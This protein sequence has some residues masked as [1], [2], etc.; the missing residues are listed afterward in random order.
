MS[1]FSGKLISVPLL[2]PR[3]KSTHRPVRH[4]LQEVRVG[5][6]VEGLSDLIDDPDGWVW[7]LVCLL[8][9]TCG[10]DE[11]AAELRTRFP[12]RSEDD[13]AA[14]IQLLYASGHLEDAAEPE[15][16]RFTSAER[17]LYGCG[18]ELLVWMDRQ[19]RRSRWE[20]Q[21]ALKDAEVV[22][23][24]TGGV[25]GIA[26]LA[27]AASGVGRVHC[28]DRDVVESSNLNRQLIYHTEDLGRPK[29]EAT[30]RRLRERY[31]NV[32]VTGEV[33]HLDSTETVREVVASFDVVLLAADRPAD[34]RSWTNR[35]C[36]DT[37]MPWV[38]GGYHGPLSKVGSYRPGTGPC[39]DCARAAEQARLTSL[40]A[41]TTVSLTDVRLPNATS[42]VTAG[43]TGLHAA[44]AVI[45]LLTGVPALPVNRISDFNFVSRRYD[46]NTGPTTP[47]PDCSTC[48]DVR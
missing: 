47:H 40:P 35:V 18:V 37:R 12:R 30:V 45:S 26:A 19:P 7:E 38:F 6:V 22:V 16:V 21:V 3:I 36:Y 14:A 13:V 4:G 27:L 17:E 9:G 15:P 39:Y 48:G 20:A 42:A 46:L 10:F 23:L 1:R 5:G 25:G 29:A 32:V 11:I 44:E 34:I 28:V 2:H 31:P 33:R 43:Q 41:R 8:N 24:G